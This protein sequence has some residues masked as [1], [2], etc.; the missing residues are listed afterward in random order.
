MRTRSRE[1]EGGEHEI[2]TSSISDIDGMDEA[3]TSSNGL[4]YL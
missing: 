3:E 4:N 1:T 2:L